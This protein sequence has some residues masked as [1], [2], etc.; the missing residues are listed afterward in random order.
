M[1]AVSDYASKVSNSTAQS[2]RARTLWTLWAQIRPRFLQNFG[3]YGGTPAIF[4]SSIHHRSQFRPTIR[5][6][7]PKIV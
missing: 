5:H 3:I 6:K 1:R 4:A 2:S 7:F